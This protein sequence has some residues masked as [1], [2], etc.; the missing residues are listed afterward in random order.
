MRT[1]VVVEG[2]WITQRWCWTCNGPFRPGEVVYVVNSPAHSR[3]S[4]GHQRCWD[5]AGLDTA[6]LQA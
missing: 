3:P 6:K 1:V 2:D 4:V 5:E